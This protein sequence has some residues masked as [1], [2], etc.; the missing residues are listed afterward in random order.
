MSTI[1]HDPIPVGAIL[2]SAAVNEPLAALDR[3]LF[4][5]YRSEVDWQ[6]FGAADPV[7]NPAAG[8]MKAFFR[9]G[10]LTLMD[11][12]GT[13]VT[14]GR[15]DMYALLQHQEAS[16]VNGDSVGTLFFRDR[17][18]NTEVIDDSGIVSLAANVFTL[19]A[20]SYIIHVSAPM[21]AVGYS[22][23]SRLYNVTDAA[24]EANGSSAACQ[25][26]TTSY[27]NIWHYMTLAGDTEFKI[28]TRQQSGA[29]RL[30]GVACNLSPEVYTQVEIW[31]L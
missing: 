31:K 12:V 19:G 16:G 4:M 3:Q 27:S 6:D 30:G 2:T 9:S 17:T 25:T 22:H 11:S 1:Y 28:Q 24:T 10:R 5:M 7:A 18:L 14:P 29:A 20:G 26:T 15:P 8:F 23:T 21:D 13:E